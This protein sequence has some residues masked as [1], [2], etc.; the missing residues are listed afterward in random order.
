MR[1]FSQ[2]FSFLNMLLGARLPVP[3]DE[4]TGACLRQMSQAHQDRH[5]F[6]VSAGKE[7]AVRLSDQFDQL[8]AILERING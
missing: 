6:L 2:S 5:G 4:L 3:A 1:E 8:K 7:L